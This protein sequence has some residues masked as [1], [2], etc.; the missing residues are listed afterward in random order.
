V[1]VELAVLAVPVV[2]HQRAL[3][4]VH[5]GRLVLAPPRDVDAAGHAEVFRH[6]HPRAAIADLEFHQDLHGLCRERHAAALRPSPSWAEPPPSTRTALRTSFFMSSS[7]PVT[8]N[9]NLNGV[10][11][12]RTLASRLWD[13]VVSSMPG[14][15]EVTPPSCFFSLGT[16]RSTPF[17][18]PPSSASPDGVSSFMSTVMEIGRAS[19]RGRVEVWVVTVRFRHAR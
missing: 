2:Q 19:W 3:A 1:R 7:V 11:P 6:V 14:M 4:R 10:S 15:S 17:M 5:L 12:P 18:R 8:S 9:T 13:T 16:C